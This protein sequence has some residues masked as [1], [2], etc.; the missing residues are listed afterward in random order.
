MNYYTLFY[1]ASIADSLK[2]AFDMFSTL[3][4]WGWVLSTLVFLLYAFY[5]QSDDFKKRLE[6]AQNNEIRIMRIW[7][8]VSLSMLVAMLL[9]WTLYVATPSRND[10]LLIIAGGAVGEFITSD[11]VVRSL[12]RETALLL[13]QQMRARV[14]ELRGDTLEHYSREQLLKLLKEKK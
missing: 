14:L 11:T 5:V 10:A 13:R 2:K 3:F 1:L 12:P 8:S 4:T 7:R 9:S 6:S